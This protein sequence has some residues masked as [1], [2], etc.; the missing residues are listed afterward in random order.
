MPQLA[1]LLEQRG[2]TAKALRLGDDLIDVARAKAICSKCALAIACLAGGLERQ[3]PWGVWGGQ[4]FVNGSIVAQ[5]RRRGRPPK[6]PRPDPVVDPGFPGFIENVAALGKLTG[7][8][9]A[10][11]RGYLRALEARR[12]SRRWERSSRRSWPWPT[13]TWCDRP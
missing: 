7:D 13:R 3:E 8:D 4:L 11:W 9:T 6:H 2:V 10:T 12:Q 5:K 1:R